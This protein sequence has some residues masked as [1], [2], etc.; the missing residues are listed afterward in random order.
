MGLL[1]R[2]CAFVCLGACAQ[3]VSTW[4][5]MRSPHFEL[6]SQAGDEAARPVLAWFEQLRAFFQ[7]Q[8]GLDPDRGSP[9]RVIAFRSA[10]E[11]QPY[12]LGPASDAYYVGAG[13]RD[14][15]VMAAPDAG[16]FHVAAHEYAHLIL[17]ASGLQRPSWLNEGLAEFFSTVRISDRGSALG[18]APPANAQILRRHEWIPLRELLSSQV[19]AVQDRER[20]GLLY[21]QCWALTE[22]LVLSPEYGPRFRALI[23]ALTLGEPSLQALATAYS[24][25][26]EAIA[27]DV[28]AWVDARHKFTPVALP[29]VVT[30]SVAVATS[31]LTPF[32]ARSLLAELL[33]A[34]G[35]LERAE[36]LYRDL[37]REQPDAADVSAALG[38]IALRQGDN[39]RARQEWK[40]AI[41]QGIGDATLCYQYAALAG[42]AGIPADEIRP[43]LE[44]AIALRPDFDDARFSLALLEKNAGHYE[45]A[46]EHL[47]A[48]RSVAPARAYSYW[49]AQADALNELGRRDEATAAAKQA[50]ARATTAAEH[51]RAAQIAYMA[52]TDLAVEFT[53]D[54]SGRALMVTTRVPHNSTDFNPFIE[55]G[56]D[57]RRVEGTLREIDCNQKMMRIVVDTSA[58][59]LRLA[60]PDP[61][62]VQMRNA[63]PEFTCGR[64]HPP[65]AV[66][67]EYAASK[68]QPDGIVRGLHFR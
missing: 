6:Y 37:A 39:G 4:R 11:Y 12:R 1:S 63:P 8:T 19:E 25:S 28:R 48:M 21:A 53:R 44:R 46:L 32:A 23:T 34:S 49:I 58:G 51:S 62:H 45:L 41:G 20:A 29:G 55:P 54:A 7:Q 68:T 31:E 61:S 42:M 5:L 56:D 3:P 60:V 10:K 47:R 13:S 65:S 52:Q 40:R 24:K 57:I 9:V 26:P 18:S 64:Q 16:E 30:E 43:A 33:M 67:A 66:T 59:P 27:L 36:A 50:S 15:I 14:Y 2:L 35:Q 38:A 22:M 17:R